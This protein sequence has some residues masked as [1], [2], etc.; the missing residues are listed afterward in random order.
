MTHPRCAS[1]CFSPMDTEH[2]HT[3]AVASCVAS[4]Q[5][6][7]ALRFC[8][9]LSVRPVIRGVTSYH[10]HV[11]RCM[12]RGYPRSIPRPPSTLRLWRA[13]SVLQLPL[14]RVRFCSCP[15]LVFTVMY[16]FFFFECNVRPIN[17]TGIL[18]SSVQP[19][20]NPAMDQPL[21]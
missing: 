2:P 15:W 21:Q 19:I 6:L 18:R 5:P 4:R 7:P 16:V 8:G 9:P 3:A 12:R 13:P 11:L 1:L 17:P 10:M 14:P 20:K